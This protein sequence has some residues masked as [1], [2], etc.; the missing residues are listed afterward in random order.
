MNFSLRRSLTAIISGVIFLSCF[1]LTV[2][3]EYS[4]VS[5]VLADDFRRGIESLDGDGRKDIEREVP[6]LE[7]VDKSVYVDSA[8]EICSILADE[9]TAGREKTAALLSVVYTAFPEVDQSSKNPAKIV[10]FL[11]QRFCSHESITLRE[12]LPKDKAR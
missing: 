10:S 4:N 5:D 11:A 6:S 8:R 3:P 9:S 1:L 7:G 12:A 2:L